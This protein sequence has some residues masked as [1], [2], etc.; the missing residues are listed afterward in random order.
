MS[1]PRPE[2]I[3]AVIVTR[4]PDDALIDRVV[5]ILRQVA[6]I[7]IIDN[8][9]APATVR[10]LEGIRFR[11][12]IHL[13]LNGE[14]DGIATA[15]NQGVG[16]AG[17]LGFDWV[18]LFD[19]D[20]EPDDDMVASLTAI[21]DRFPDRE[22][23]AVRLDRE[24]PEFTFP[25]PDP[26]W[27][28]RRSVI[29]SGSLIPLDRHAE[30]GPFRDALFIDHV[31]DEYSFRARRLGFHVIMSRAPL[32]RHAIGVRKEHRAFFRTIETSNHSPERRYYMGRNVVLVAR[33]YLTAEPG[34]VVV[35]GWKIVKSVILIMLF[36][37]DRM[38]KV[39]NLLRGVWHGLRGREGRLEDL[40]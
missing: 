25:G 27:V 5:S 14:N 11:P 21:F 32:M 38:A 7:V 28:E 31:D 37:R 35:K 34:W 15:L 4:D 9:S 26:P 30:V 16:R 6:A 33:E 23:L 13:I 24:H 36:E 10:M 12:G 29:T 39:W 1:P 3:C 19:H 40:I 2:T 18:A 8:G 22:T 20:S 17:E